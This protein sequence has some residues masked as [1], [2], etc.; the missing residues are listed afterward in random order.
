MPKLPKPKC[1]ACGGTG[2][3][4][5]GKTCAPCNGTGEAKFRRPR[6]KHK[7]GKSGKV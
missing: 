3:S 1:I 7:V 5:R 4:S 2:E 6:G